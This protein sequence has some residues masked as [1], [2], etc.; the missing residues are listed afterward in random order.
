MSCF[1]N[2]GSVFETRGCLQILPTEWWDLQIVRE[3]AMAESIDIFI[4]YAY[5]D[6]NLCDE[7]LKWLRPQ[8]IVGRINVWH[9]GQIIPGTEWDEAIKKHLSTAHLIILLVSPDFMAS[10]Y[11]NRIEMTKALERHDARDARVIPIIIRPADW[12]EAPFSKLQVLPTKGV[13]VVDWP[14]GRDNG[15]RNV[16]QGIRRAVDE[17]QV[18]QKELEE[19]KK[20]HASLISLFGYETDGGTNS[21]LW[22]QP[23]TF[24]RNE[25]Y[26]EWWD[27]K[28]SVARKEFVDHTWVK[29]SNWG[30]HWIVR[31]HASKDPSEN[32]KGPL[33]E[34]FL[35]DPNKQWPGSWELVDGILRIKIGKCEIE[36]FANREN[37]TYSAIEFE[38]DQKQANAYHVFFPLQ[39]NQA[40][41]WDLR[42]V[43]FLV[44]ELCEQVLNRRATVREQLLY[45]SLLHRGEMSARGIVKL[46]GLSPE[47][48]QMF[49]DVQKPGETI[50]RCYEHFLDRTADGG[51]R[52]HYSNK[53]KKTG[54]DAITVELIESPEYGGL[55]G[56]D[57]PPQI[58]L[59]GL[60]AV[61]RRPN[62]LECFYRGRDHQLCHRYR[63][64]DGQ[65]S[66]EGDLGGVLTSAPAA[67]SWDPGADG[68]IDCFYRSQDDRLFHRWYD[69]VWQKERDL[70][71]YLTSAP[72]VASL[73]PG[74]LDCFYRGADGHL[75]HRWGD[76]NSWDREDD[77]G[78]VL[79]A[80]PA[81][82]CSGP[83]RI[84]CIIR[85]EDQHLWH[86]RWEK[87]A[88][89]SEWE[90]LGGP[91]ASSA[92]AVASWHANRFD[93]FFRGE[94]QHL[95]HRRCSGSTWGPWEDL[96][97]T[98]TSA[99]TAVCWGPGRIDCFY[100][101]ESEHLWHKW[102]DGSAWNREDRGRLSI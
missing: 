48:R 68:R 28:R 52:T 9:D 12:E 47:Y 66:S 96:G 54:F 94:N 18:Q 38:Q 3:K 90:N 85:G 23:L 89:W 39:T 61:S 27:M 93:C 60:A 57:A 74:H 98:L 64:E 11:C 35:S 46:L 7:L 21:K 63:Y 86:R 59:R 36:V 71:G 22:T 99:P 67:I 24:S 29:V 41:H 34:S 26:D 51:G 78:G 95:W 100:R 55:F 30:D 49:I 87:S 20:Q 73:G 69:G 45:G 62:H 101:G 8:E 31:F 82:V 25:R 17:W 75:W 91:L 84:D 97:D 88:G 79:T 2:R 5:E 33:D 32:L 72:A 37:S 65:W 77:L 19:W 4:S 92:P 70:G 83:D 40:E 14:G 10:E 50:A 81:V 58:A 53:V 76:G 102:W 42:V 1:G 15:F 13:P 80:A 16:N 6:K 44:D 43:P 56:E